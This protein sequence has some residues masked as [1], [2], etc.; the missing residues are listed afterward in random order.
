MTSTPFDRRKNSD[1]SR[2]YPE[3]Y[4]K[5]VQDFLNTLDPGAKIVYGKYM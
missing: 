2:Y 4:K 1:G 3:T 5:K